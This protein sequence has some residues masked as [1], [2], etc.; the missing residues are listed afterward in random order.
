MEQLEKS[1]DL[2]SA[3]YQMF[4][5]EPQRSDFSNTVDSSPSSLRGDAADAALEDDPD[6][7]FDI[8]DGQSYAESPQPSI[9]P[10]EADEVDWDMET[11]S[12]PPPEPA[13]H[14]SFDSLKEISQ[15]LTVLVNQRTESIVHTNRKLQSRSSIAVGSQK[16]FPARA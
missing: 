3:Y 10:Q 4:R 9:L 16:N 11:Q 15:A 13:Q 12:Q 6:C 1:E 2:M 7:P 14:Q 8:T 5:E